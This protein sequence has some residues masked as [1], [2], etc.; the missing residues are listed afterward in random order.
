MRWSYTL[1]R[2]A[3]IPI[4]VHL[5]FLLLLAWAA[6]T[7]GGLGG[8]LF[9]LVVFGVVVLHELGHALAARGFGIETRDITLLPIGGVA[10]LERMPRSPFQE[11]I[12]ALA[13]PAVNAGL[14]LA[15][16]G[17]LVVVAASPN[18]VAFAPF[19]IK[20]LFVN[21][22]LGLFNLIP[23]FPMDGG[24]AFRALLAMRT[25]FARATRIAARTGRWLAG[26]LALVGLFVSPALVFVAAFV[27]L[28]GRQEEW[29]A[30]AGPQAVP[31]PEPRASSYKVYD[32]QG[33]LVTV[34]LH[35]SR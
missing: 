6:L 12:V 35:D 13:G 32:S 22:G 29:A 10:R 28:A 24:R 33:R 26:A 20:F 14:A 25:S 30:V 3:G 8:V 5:T 19:L 1:G 23:A 34:Y 9:T 16:V 7:E 4:R 31:F 21:V 15:A 18:L 11:L 2:I 27:W 17:A